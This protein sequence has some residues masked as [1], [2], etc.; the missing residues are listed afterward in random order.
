MRNTLKV[1][2]LVVPLKDEIDKLIFLRFQ[3]TMTMNFPKA[4]K[5]EVFLCKEKNV[6]YQSFIQKLLILGFCFICGW[7]SL[8]GQ[9][10]TIDDA[11]FICFFGETFVA[12][13]LVNGRNAYAY[14]SVASPN[15]RLEW[16]G[17][18]WEIFA[19]SN[20]FLI[21]TTNASP[22]PPNNTDAAA[23][24]TP[25]VAGPACTGGGP[26]TITGTGTATTISP[27]CTPPIANCKNATVALSSGGTIAI[28]DATVNDSSSGDLACNPVLSVTPQMFTCSGIGPNTVTLT[29]TDDDSNTST[30]T[31]TVTI[32][33]NQDPVANCQ[34]IT[35]QLEEPGDDKTISGSDVDSPGTP[36]SDNCGITLSVSPNYFTTSELGTQ[37]FTLTVTDEDSNTST[38]TGMAIVMD[39]FLPIELLFFKGESVPEGNAL[40][41]ATATEINNA[42]FTIE[43]SA[44]GRDWI[45][46]GTIDGMGNSFEQQNYEYLDRIPA[47]VPEIY[48]RLKQTDF[49]GTFTYSDIIRL[50]TEEHSKLDITVAPNPV[51]RNFNVY[52]SQMIDRADVALVLYALDGRKLPLMTSWQGTVL[53]VSLPGEIASGMY[54]LVVEINSERIIKE[55]IVR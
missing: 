52:L 49:D 23:N 8:P 41:W 38:C 9:T 7:T 30:C 50:A 26:F 43:R 12:N 11:G 4:Q 31:A 29:I 2:R 45:E 46:V 44:N 5:P 54:L 15:F 14:P 1:N 19:G 28:S 42:F 25:W 47:G 40:R 35:V 17:S 53:D 55:I 13:G 20:V 37:T 27:S 10:V 22:N 18:Q 24:G 3:N 21:T 34:D 48:Y 16:S 6:S 33:D 39:D 32:Q 36:S 51:N